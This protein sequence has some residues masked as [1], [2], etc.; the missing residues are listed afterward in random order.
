MNENDIL[1]DELCD[2]LF[3]DLDEAM[4]REAEHLMGEHKINP[5]LMTRIVE[6]FLCKRARQVEQ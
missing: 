1:F 2:L 3:P 5:E 6:A 4:D